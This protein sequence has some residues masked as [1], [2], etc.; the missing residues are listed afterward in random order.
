MSVR[1]GPKARAKIRASYQRELLKEAEKAGVDIN[2]PQ[3]V[4]DFDVKRMSAIFDEARRRMKPK[5]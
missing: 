3:A 4:A 1:K 5:Q 2:D